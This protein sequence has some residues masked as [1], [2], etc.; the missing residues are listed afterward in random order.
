MNRTIRIMAID[1][2]D[3]LLDAVALTVSDDFDRI[4]L[5]LGSPSRIL[6]TADADLIIGRH[7][8]SAG[9]AK[10]EERLM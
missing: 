8:A 4:Q 5:K 9:C 1:H 7:P 6:A 10:G 2:D 3:I